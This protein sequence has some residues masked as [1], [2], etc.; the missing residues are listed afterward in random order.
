MK[1]EVYRSKVYTE[2]PAYADF[3]APAKFQAI[4]SIIARRLREHPT[5]NIT[6]SATPMPTR[7]T[8]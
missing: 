5:R 4:Q 8:A 6:A 7:S 1:E 2:R 3:D